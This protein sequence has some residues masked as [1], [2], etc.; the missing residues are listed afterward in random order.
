MRSL[1]YSW[2]GEDVSA[3]L[4]EWARLLSGAQWELDYWM[5]PDYD[6]EPDSDYW[7]IADAIELTNSL[8]E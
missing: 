8:R 2:T 5:T 3:Q 1:G 7:A 4:G 6:D